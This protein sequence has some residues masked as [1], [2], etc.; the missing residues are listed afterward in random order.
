AMWGE[1]DTGSPLEGVRCAFLPADRLERPGTR[2][3]RAATFRLDKFAARIAMIVYDR[4]LDFVR[5]D[6]EMSYMSIRRAHLCAHARLFRHSH[7]VWHFHFSCS[8]VQ[9]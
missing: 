6:V 5:L 4:V 7:L 2:A 9:S 1:D 8:R 3:A